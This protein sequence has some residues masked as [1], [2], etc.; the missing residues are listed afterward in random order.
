[1]RELIK[2]ILFAL[3]VSTLSCKKKEAPRETQAPGHSASL[4]PQE[5]SLLGHWI[6]ESV[7][8]FNS[9][10]WMSSYRPSNTSMKLQGTSSIDGCMSPDTAYSYHSFGGIS[11]N[12]QWSSKQNNLLMVSLIGMDP[13]VTTG[14]IISLTGSSLVLKISRNQPPGIYNL[15]Y[16][17]K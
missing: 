2:Y 4:T 11:R 13:C 3:V 7:A 15:N 17:N 6:L 5:E 8:P 12:G 9:T 14:T 1:M 10:V 16:F